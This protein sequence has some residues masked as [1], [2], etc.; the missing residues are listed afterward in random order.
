MRAAETFSRASLL[1]LMSLVV[2]VIAPA[3]ARADL[4]PVVRT[5]PVTYMSEREV[6]GHAVSE[7]IPVPPA[8]MSFLFKLIGDPVGG[9]ASASW[10]VELSCDGG[11]SWPCA[12]LHRGSDRPL[13]SQFGT[14]PF[15]TGT[16]G[17][18]P[19]VAG[20]LPTHARF[21]VDVTGTAILT[22][23]GEFYAP[24][25]V[26]ITLIPLRAGGGP[27]GVALNPTTRLLYV[28]DQGA[29]YTV[30][31]IDTTSDAIVA[32]IPLN[33]ARNHFGVAVNPVTNRIYVVSSD[34]VEVIDGNTN[35]LIASFVVSSPGGD[36]A[37]AVNPGTNRIYVTNSAGGTLTV[38]DGLT[39]G[40]LARVSVGREPVSVAVNPET[41]RIYVASRLEDPITVVD[42]DIN[43]VIATISTGLRSGGIAVNPNTDTLY[44]STVLGKS[45][46]VIDGRTNQ[47]TAAIP[48]GHFIE[49]VTVDSVRNRIY[50]VTGGATVSHATSYVFVVDG[51]THDVISA[52]PIMGCCPRPQ[53]IDVRSETQRIYVEGGNSWVTSFHDNFHGLADLLDLTMSASAPPDPV[54]LGADFQMTFTITNATQEPGPGI[55]TNLTAFLRSGFGAEFSATPGDATC[56]PFFAA[57]VLRC[58]VAKLEKGES[59][60]ITVAVRPVRTGQ[61]F[62]IGNVTAEQADIAVSN[63]AALR[64]TTVVNP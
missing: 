19:V 55:A 59:A 9:P 60:S 47:V 51:K 14:S 36:S 18:M 25:G 54:A 7:A 40:L 49:T 32:R 48:L 15:G 53:G 6:T 56:D 58:T 4:D 45:V 31:V 11:L 12:T 38:V 28:V 52:V 10:S 43:S 26:D 50:A 35:S 24:I 41:N 5:F 37:V 13:G 39:H 57:S 33:E 20:P 23:T 61:I 62:I 17:S 34:S 21:V 2:G 29:P 64:T 8:A 30:S 16:E 44:V 63:N 42:G 27:W 1:T 22:V 3:P 46:L